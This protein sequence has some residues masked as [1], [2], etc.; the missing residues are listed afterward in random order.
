MSISILSSSPGDSDSKES[1]CN[2]GD[3]GSVLGVEIY[4]GG[5][6]GNPLQ[7]SLLGRLQSFGL[8][9]DRATDNEHTGGST[10]GAGSREK[11]GRGGQSWGSPHGFLHSQALQTATLGGPR[12]GGGSR[13]PPVTG[14]QSPGE[15][16]WTMMSRLAPSKGAPGG[17]WFQSRLYL[18]SQ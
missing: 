5:G 14:G 16:A 7:Y 8:Q 6:H 3:L 12:E 13:G 17:P 10:V 2:V 15:R 1:A 11:T 9:R 4:P 18:S